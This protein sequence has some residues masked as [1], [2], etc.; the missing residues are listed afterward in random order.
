MAMLDPHSSI[1]PGVQIKHG[2]AE[3][4][5]LLQRIAAS[6]RATAIVVMLAISLAFAAG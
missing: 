3:L 2:H 5:P 1:V 4:R 6:A